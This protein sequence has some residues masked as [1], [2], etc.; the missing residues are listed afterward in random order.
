MLSLSRPNISEAA[1][2]QVANVLRS[3]NLVYGEEAKAFEAE[4]ADMTNCSEAVLVSS[5]TAA[6]YLAMIGLKIGPGDV[7]IVP[8][9]TFPATVNAVIVAGATPLIVDVDPGTYCLNP[10]TVS[11]VIK[12][13]E[14]SGKLKAIMLVHEFGT[15]CDMLA[16]LKL[17]ERHNLLL[18]EDAACA[19]G[20]KSNNGPIGSG[21]TLACFSFHPRKTITTGEGGLLT[22]DDPELA[23]R[24]RLLRNHGRVYAENEIDFGE[25]ALNFRL[26]DFQAALGRSQLPSLSD[27]IQ[28]RH[29]I[30]AEYKSQLKGMAKQGL[31]VLPKDVPGQSWQTFM[32]VLAEQFNRDEISRQM[33]LKGIEAGIG[34][35]ALG[36]LTAYK[37]YVTGELP[38]SRRLYRNG[39]AL[40]MCE[41]MSIDD[42]STV[43]QTLKKML[44]EV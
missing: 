32:V 14:G 21:S 15:P 19:L 26:T 39:L 36:D 30:A 29:L 38:I 43:C 7:V 34:A 18:V 35:Q 3:G 8:A 10:S 42:V 9:F 5:G 41:L 4:L 16:F 1:I 6:L 40:P 23:D 11:Q 31:L 13:F 25:A 24:L 2:R 37:S 33:K 12:N 44:Q 17:A 27:W 20:A 22:T 28:K